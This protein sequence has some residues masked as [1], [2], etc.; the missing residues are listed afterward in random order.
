VAGKATPAIAVAERAGIAFT[1]HEYTHDPKA[2]SYGLEAAEKLGLDP[3]RVFKTLVADVDGTLTVAVVPV[4]AQ[5]DLRALGKRAAM[6]DVK[7]AERATGYVAGGISPLG[8]RKRLATVVDES[9]LVH[10]T[11]NVSAGRRGLEIEIAPGDLVALTG[12]RVAAIARA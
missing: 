7:A 9:A 8:Q 1:V 2:P 11:I 12:A 6:A 3:A 4:E 10:P 5:L